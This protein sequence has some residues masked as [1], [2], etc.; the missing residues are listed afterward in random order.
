MANGWQDELDRIIDDRFERMV[1]LRRHMHRHPE[2]SGHEH[3]TSLHIL[4]LL[5]EEDFE[6]RVGPDGRG[7]IVDNIAGKIDRDMLALRADI[8]ALRIHDQKQVEYRSTNAGLMHACG[9]DA[10]T[11]VV[12]G[13]ITAVRQMHVAKKL[14]WDVPLRA[15]FQPAEETC[16]GAR[17]MIDA[18]ALEGVSTIF[19]AHVDPT[20][21]VG[22]VGLRTGPLTAAVDMLRIVIEGR[23]GHAA[24]P[25]E[26]IDPIATAAQMIN[27]IYLFVPR[28][29]DSQDAVVVTIGQILGGDNPNVIPEAVELCGTIRTL[30]QGVREET[31]AHIRRLAS[32]L[33]QATGAG[34]EVKLEQGCGSVDNGSASISLFQRS[35]REVLGDEGVYM[36]PRASMGA[37]DFALYLEQ[38]PGAMFRLGCVSDQHGGSFLHTPNFDIDEEALRIGAKVMARAAI[39]WAESGAGE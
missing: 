35:V 6:L 4:K 29:T 16:M 33:A 27:S 24:R 37:E 21:K 2:P 18:G 31:I 1:A 14:P 39:H 34:I 8:D 26:T 11:A 25:H 9:H 32:G 28:A 15:I 19:A 22:N 30:D 3:K 17:E 38:I 23:G 7:L 12:Y 5:A 10:H 20:L 13:A 36:I